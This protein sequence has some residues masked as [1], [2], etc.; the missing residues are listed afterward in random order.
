MRDTYEPTLEQREAD[1]M[2]IASAVLRS[3]VEA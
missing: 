1:E 3:E 2:R